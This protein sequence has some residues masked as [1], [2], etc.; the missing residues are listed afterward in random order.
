MKYR[1]LSINKAV[2]DNGEQTDAYEIQD[3]K[4]GEQWWVVPTVRNRLIYGRLNLQVHDLILVDELTQQKW[5]I[6]MANKIV[7][8]TN[9][10]MPGHIN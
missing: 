6:M 10:E 9:P 8:L 5:P 4:T 2:D 1:V 7:K 3:P